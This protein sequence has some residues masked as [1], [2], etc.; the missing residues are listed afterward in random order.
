MH[1]YDV[2]IIYRFIKGRE[3]I[4]HFHSLRQRT[5]MLY[6]VILFLNIIQLE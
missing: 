5:L 3:N 4:V 1:F 6:I 2:D